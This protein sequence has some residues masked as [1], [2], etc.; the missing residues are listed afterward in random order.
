MV[1]TWP[2]TVGGRLGR[3]LGP[4]EDAGGGEVFIRPSSIVIPVFNLV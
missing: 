4:A 3:V 2:I 1:R